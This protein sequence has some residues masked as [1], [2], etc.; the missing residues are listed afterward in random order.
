MLLLYFIHFYIIAFSQ[1]NSSVLCSDGIDNDGDGLI[2]CADGDCESICAEAL[3]GEC[4]TIDFES[5]L[6]EEPTNLTPIENQ[7][8]G[9]GVQFTLSSGEIPF[10]VDYGGDGEAFFGVGPD[11][12]DPSYEDEL[13]HYF[14]TDDGISGGLQ[15]ATMWL[16]FQLP[17]NYVSGFILDIDNQETFTARAL[18]SFGNL[19]DEQIITNLSLNTGNGVPTAWELNANGACIT[20]VVLAGTSDGSASFGYGLDNFT[21]CYL[22]LEEVC[23]CD[24]ISGQSDWL[25]NICFGCT[26][27]LACNYNPQTR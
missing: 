22:E 8:L 26:D 9:Q 14:L 25:S 12:P 15:T 5:V 13:G 19:I 2:D 11:G 1:E 24:M 3:L 27:P 23:E 18:D 16:S 7:F 6:G 20:K 10:L 21:F 4:V 17:V